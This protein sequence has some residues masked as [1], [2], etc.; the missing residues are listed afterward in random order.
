LYSFNAHGRYLN[1]L[2]AK[3][4]GAKI[5][6]IHHSKSAPMPV[7]E[8]GSGGYLG[9]NFFFYAVAMAV[10]AYERLASLP[11]HGVLRCGEFQSSFGWTA[12][13]GEVIVECDLECVEEMIRQR[14]IY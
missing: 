3:F 2:K 5:A 10:G 6:E 13:E 4:P 1:W 14:A 9:Y 12:E 8:L 7:I 11:R